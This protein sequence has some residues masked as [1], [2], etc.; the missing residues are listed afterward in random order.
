MT[1]YHEDFDLGEKSISERTVLLVCVCVCVC[2]RGPAMVK[3]IVC[4]DL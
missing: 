4:C 2:V 3:V 1:C